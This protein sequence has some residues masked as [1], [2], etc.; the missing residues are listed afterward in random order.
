MSKDEAEQPSF[1]GVGGDL[2]LRKVDMLSDIESHE[3]TL[4]DIYYSHSLLSSAL[5]PSVE[6][7]DGVEY[8]SKTNGSME[9]MLE[10]GIDGATKRRRFPYG[11]YPRLIMAWMAK[12]I[13]AAGGRRTEYVDPETHTIVIPSIWQLCEDLGISH[14]GT[15]NDALQEQLHRLLSCRISIHRSAGTGFRG[16]SV[17]DTVY[18]PIVEA[19]RTVDDERRSYYSGAAFVLTAEVYRRLANESAPFDI[20][21]ATYLLF[22]KSVLP[23]DIYVWMAGSMRELRH[24]LPVSWD[25][26]YERFGDSIGDMQNFRAKFRRALKKVRDVYPELRVTDTRKGLILHPSPTPIAP[27][28]GRPRKT[29]N[30]ADSSRA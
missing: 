28:R 25:W 10:A 5:F 18:L 3:P 24:D 12:Q 14:G 30:G 9:Y 27:R 13:R 22:G 19:V 11:K 29:G 15:A 2:D 26:L 23:Y 4:K 7:D 6:P 21:A 20:R 17:H 16:R 1:E 8:V